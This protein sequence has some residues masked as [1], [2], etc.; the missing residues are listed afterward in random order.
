VLTRPVSF[1]DLLNIEDGSSSG[2]T[3]QRA[4]DLAIRA[5]RLG[6]RRY[7]FAEHH[8]TPALPPAAPRS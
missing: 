4:T 7:W 3:L 2:E 5:E 1:L 8:N 6:Y